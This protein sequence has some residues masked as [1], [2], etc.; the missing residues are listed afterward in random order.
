MKQAKAVYAFNARSDAEIS[1]DIGDV[2][3]ILEE[4]PSGWGKGRTKDY[5]EGYFPIAYVQ[6]EELLD[7]DSD[8]EGMI[9]LLCRLHIPY[10]VHRYSQGAATITMYCHV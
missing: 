4:D 10:S 2:I 9:S 3:V 6:L 5:K 7:S 1:F 8:D